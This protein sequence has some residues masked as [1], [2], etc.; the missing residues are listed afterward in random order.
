MKKINLK[1]E[2]TRQTTIQLLK[3][4]V[5][6]VS[7]TVITAVTFYLLNTWLGAPY[8][9]ANVSG[10][11]LGVINSFVWNRSWV[12]NAKGKGNVWRQGILFLGGFFV[13]MI[14]QGLVSWILLEPVGMKNLPEDIIPFLPMK[15]AGQNIV[16]LIAMVVYTIANYIWNR[17]VTFKEIKNEEL[18]IQN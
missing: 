17:T 8:G 12:F 13:C 15:H 2:K 14:L 10:Y 3:Y 5:I 9:V 4:G 16:M 1:D 7:N 18:E 11:V 6:G